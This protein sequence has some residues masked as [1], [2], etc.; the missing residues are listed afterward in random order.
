MNNY[1]VLGIMS[2]TSLDGLDLALCRFYKEG[3]EWKYNIEKV[4]TMPYSEY[5]HDQLS[6]AHKLSLTEF[7]LLHKK[8]GRFIGE[9]VNNFCDGD[10]YPDL[11][12]SHG[13]TVF[14]E[15]AN[16]LTFQ[17]G[18][19]ATLAAT[20]RINTVCDFRSFDVALGGQ[21][22]PLVPAGDELLFGC[23]DYCLNLGGF[24]N[25]SYRENNRRIAFDICPANTVINYLAMQAGK[26]FDDK[27]K[28]GSTGRIIMPLLEALDSIAYYRQP[29][30]KSLGREWLE[31]YFLPVISNTRYSIPDLLRT[32]YQHIAHQVVSN[33]K[34]NRQATMLVTGGGAFNEFLIEL[35]NEIAPCKI[36]IP[37]N[38][39]IKYKEALIFAFLG[40]LRFLHEINCLSSVTGAKTDSS[41]GVVYHINPD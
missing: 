17:L 24:A 14:H 33:L 31:Q 18:D 38:K 19:G 28:I 30:P 39:L 16:G 6:K 7:L 37:D 9:A 5:W 10:T 29:P 22:A 32:V 13:H 21:G 23:Y 41:S 3:T 25:I 8:Y 15:P 40:L 36:I 2:G 4:S 35:M 11:V 27:G 34:N 26:E 20:C 12:A 1:Y